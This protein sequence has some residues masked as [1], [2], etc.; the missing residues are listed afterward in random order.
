VLIVDLSA[1]GMSSIISDN[2]GNYR[3]NFIRFDVFN[4][5]VAEE[6]HIDFAYFAIHDS[7]EEIYEANSDMGEVTLFQNKMATQIGTAT[8]Q[9][10]Q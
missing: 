4:A 9:P 1:S 5:A 2:E 8:G 10:V 7:L 3:I 6:A